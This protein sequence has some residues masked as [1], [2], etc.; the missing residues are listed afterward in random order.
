M[1]AETTQTG[2]SGKTKLKASHLFVG[3]KRR[4]IRVGVEFHV[5]VDEL[6]RG[7]SPCCTA[8]KRTNTPDARRTQ[9]KAQPPQRTPSTREA[10]QSTSQLD[11]IQSCR[12]ADST[13][14]TRLVDVV[15]D[16]INDLALER[17]EH[18]RAVSRDELGLPASRE[19]YTTPDVENGDDSDDVAELPR[20]GAFDV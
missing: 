2:I 11:A 1:P 15:D 9:S 8:R 19:H 6:S 16:T 17:L 4:R 18:N 3:G 10:C 12:R 13:I 14:E 20:T 5:W 7:M